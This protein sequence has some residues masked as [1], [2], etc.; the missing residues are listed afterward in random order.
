MHLKMPPPPP[1]FPR[2]NLLAK[3]RQTW[4]QDGMSTAQYEIVWR[5]EQLPLYTNIT[6]HVGTEAGLRSRPPPT[7]PLARLT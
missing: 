7:K 2:H 6:V 1:P 4:K 3:S 5:E